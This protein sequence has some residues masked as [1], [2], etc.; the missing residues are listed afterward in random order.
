MPRLI[1]INNE[2]DFNLK[3]V[4]NFSFETLANV[5]TSTVV[6]QTFILSGT[7]T[8]YVIGHIYYFAGVGVQGANATGWLDLSLI[9]PTIN[10]QA[11]S[12]PAGGGAI[13]APATGAIGDLYI[14]TGAVGDVGTLFG[15]N[16][17]LGDSVTIISAYSSSPTSANFNIKEDPRDAASTA[18]SGNIRLATQAE[19]DL[20]TDNLTAITPASLLSNRATNR[21][22]KGSQAGSTANPVSLTTDVDSD[23][24]H[25]LSLTNYKNV[26]VQIRLNSTGERVNIYQAAKDANTVTLNSGVTGSFWVTVIGN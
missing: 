1:K 16:V 25:N 5:P 7:V 3:A 26:E 6:G 21:I 17:R 12:I 15:Y 4:H 24:I 18:I 13:T 22:A 2:Q 11:L 14:A 10:I 9:V 19:V 23:F 20:G 8:N